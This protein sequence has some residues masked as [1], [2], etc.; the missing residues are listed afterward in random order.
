[1]NDF[2]RLGDVVKVMQM[3]VV[4]AN[5]KPVGWASLLLRS[6]DLPS[7]G[8]ISALQLVQDLN[9]PNYLGQSGWQPER[10]WIAVEGSDDGAGQIVVELG[11]EV[12]RHINAHS[13]VEIR[14]SA[15]GA[16]AFGSGH[17]IWP[18][19]QQQAGS[20]R[21]TRRIAVGGGRKAEPEAPAAPATPPQAAAPTEVP[22]AQSKQAGTDQSATGTTSPS[23]K[24]ALIIGGVI[25]SVVIIGGVLTFVFFDKLPFG[26]NGDVTETADQGAAQKPMKVLTLDEVRA[27][28]SGSAPLSP[29]D[30]VAQADLQMGAGNLDAA[31][32]LYKSA[33]QAGSAAGATGF[34]KMYDPGLHGPK[35]SPFGQPNADRAVALYEKAANLG[36][37]FAMRR[38]G[39][40][41]YEGG[42]GI[43][44]DKTTG[45]DW[46]D[47]AAEAGDAEAK[48]YLKNL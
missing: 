25:A 6:S 15:D 28:L 40:L 11:P 46:L 44:A 32:L 30:I 10:A 41:L 29:E 43:S 18:A 24:M 37:A 16:N 48:S 22:P 33:E 19:I 9:G 38:L 20:S 27:Q 13:N 5:S 23:N 12:T 14:A 17:L 47:K 42:N 21:R 7:G 4:E 31:L 34:A 1:M 2:L 36:D 39:I 35:T 8:S 26:F 3:Q 45:K